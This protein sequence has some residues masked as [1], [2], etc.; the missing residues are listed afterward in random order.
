[1]NR[2]HNGSTETRRDQDFLSNLS[3]FQ[4]TEHMARNEFVFSFVL[5]LLLPGSSIRPLEVHRNDEL[6]K[7]MNHFVQ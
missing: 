7:V 6:S 5:V 3:F 1:M 2:L 4:T